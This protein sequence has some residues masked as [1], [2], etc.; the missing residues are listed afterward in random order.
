MQSFLYILVGLAALTGSMSAGRAAIP[1]NSPVEVPTQ[2][3]TAQAALESLPDRSVDVIRH[4]ACG[5]EEEFVDNGYA[6]LDTGEDHLIQLTA[7]AAWLMRTANIPECDDTHVMQSSEL[8]LPD[9]LHKDF[10]SPDPRLTAPGVPS[11][12][13]VKPLDQPPPQDPCANIITF[14]SANTFF[15]MK[16]RL[17]DACMR[18]ELNT[19][20]GA[21]VRDKQVGSS[22]LPCISNLLT[23]G[24]LTNGEWDVTV[25]DLTRIRYFDRLHPVARPGSPLLDP[26]VRAHLDD[27]LLNIRGA[28]GQATYHVTA[29][30][31]TEN[32]TGDPAQR[33]ADVQWSQSIGGQATSGLSQLLAS[34]FNWLLA[35]LGVAAVGLLASLLGPIGPIVA[36]ILAVAGTVAAVL[37]LIGSWLSIPETENHRLMIETARYLEN[38]A[39]IQA[40]QAVSL[41]VDAVTGDQQGVR[42]WLLMK[43]Q[44]ILTNDFAEYNGRPYQRYSMIAMLNLFDFSNDANL[45]TAG[46]IGNDYAYAKFAVG[47]NQGRRLAPFRRRVDAIDERVRAPDLTCQVKDGTP[48]L[49]TCNVLADSLFGETEVS[50]YMVGANALYTGESSELQTLFVDS[51]GKDSCLKSPCF[52]D[53]VAQT[54]LIA[55]TSGYVPDISS[56]DL[57]LSDDYVASQKIHHAGLE[58]YSRGPGYLL[59]AGGI[60]APPTSEVML[61]CPPGVPFCGDAGVGIASLTQLF[62]D[63]TDEGFGV[64]TTLMLSGVP[65]PSKRDAPGGFRDFVSMTGKLIEFSGSSATFDRN[66]CIWGGFACGANI[67]VS[68]VAGCG[69]QQG[70]WLFVDTAK[71]TPPATHRSFITIYQSVCPP[72]PT[73]SRL[74]DAIGCEANFGFV[75]IM[76][77]PPG[78]LD[79]FMQAVIAANPDATVADPLT[80]SGTFKTPDRHLVLY[81]L[82]SDGL[83][84]PQIASVDGYASPAPST[85]PLA[86]GDVLDGGSGRVAIHDPRL[87]R[88][89]LLDAS[90][91]QHPTRTPILP[92]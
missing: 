13:R 40:D 59:T 2:P 10:P 64:P 82:D 23:N 53:K 4:M 47:S 32:T 42:N 45:A 86:Q 20:L 87:H 80:A 55:A 17:T 48:D 54:G 28:L 39:D 3:A 31:D 74:R 49:S 1:E 8:G 16:T 57:A 11:S 60:R 15:L 19:Y 67:D 63:H 56:I 58:I 83:T 90:D 33:A 85:W 38:Q 51:Q 50:D 24:P 29:C 92:Q 41:P 71:C 73:R 14:T 27:V 44:S 69:V 62:A 70:A 91:W 43:T 30:G 22:G 76:P 35:L 12:N 75:Y 88:G 36:G 68:K 78:T 81:N 25:R 9:R 79:A 77:A 5:D 52:T 37:L 46:A 18:L 7:K 84:K 21:M 6:K 61:G 34:L 72:T 65:D 89:L 66:A 26:E